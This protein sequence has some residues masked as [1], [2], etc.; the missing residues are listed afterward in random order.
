MLILHYVS[1]TR[2]A[3]KMKK[4]FSFFLIIVALLVA[5]FSF[6][7]L[8]SAANPKAVT[9]YT[10]Q[11]TH[12]YRDKKGMESILILPTNT[13][14]YFLHKPA[15]GYYH[16]T[17]KKTSGYINI[18]NCFKS[19]LTYFKDFEETWY[20]SGHKT[21]FISSNVPAV[22]KEGKSIKQSMID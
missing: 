1:I 6:S 12:L 5:C 10:A 15:K 16:V 4:H 8:A 22:N 7:S 18:R 13:K 17:Y 2:R 9:Y 21:I 14:F 11:G 3:L 20:S 19:Q